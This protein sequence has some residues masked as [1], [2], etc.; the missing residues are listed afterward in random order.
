MSGEVS[1]ESVPDLTLWLER[2]A[3]SG[4]SRSEYGG[5]LLNGCVPAGLRDRL[6]LSETALASLPFCD[7]GPSEAG[8][9]QTGWD[10]DALVALFLGTGGR[11]WRES[12]LWLSTRPI[13]EWHG[14]IVDENVRV[15]RLEL[16]ENDL[17]GRIP[18]QLGGL[19]NLQVLELWG[20]ELKGGIPAELGD[21]SNLRTLELGANELIGEIPPELGLLYNLKML[22]LYRN[23]LVGAIPPELGDLLSLQRLILHNNQLGGEIPSELGNLEFLS[24]LSLDENRLK[25]KIPPELGNLLH[26]QALSLHDNRLE[27]ELPA[28]LGR[29]LNLTYLRIEGNGLAGCVPVYRQGKFD[30]H[31]DL[32]GLSF[33]DMASVPQLDWTLLSD[34]Y[35]LAEFYYATRGL[36]WK[37]KCNWLSPKPLDEWHGVTTD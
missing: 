21:L 19:S 17:N 10:R 24:S 36:F 1:P 28:E 22:Y 14:V 2:L 34:R 13:G 26:L 7:A 30:E 29:L 31:S 23:Q 37:E 11:S 15:T 8:P 33:C 4:I 3:V 12:D 18:P 20:N 6:E 27:G 9:S 35:A 5:N 32:G 25:G 16:G